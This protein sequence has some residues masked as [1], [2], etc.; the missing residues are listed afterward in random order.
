MRACVRL[1]CLLCLV[2]LTARAAN[3]G[4]SLVVVARGA[5]SGGPAPL[6]G[7]F[8]NDVMVGQ[9]TA[10]SAAPVAY[11]IPVRSLPAGA[12]I[13]IVYA[14]APDRPGVPAGTRSLTID[15]ITVNGA[16]VRPTDA[17]VVLDGQR[18]YP[19]EAKYYA[20]IWDGLYTQR[21][22]ATLSS[23][24][25][26]RFAAPVGVPDA[27]PAPLAPSPTLTVRARAASNA[28]GWPILVLRVN[29]T[30]VG[31]VQVSSTAAA[32][33]AVPVKSLPL[34]AKV[35]VVAGAWGGATGRGVNGAVIESVTMNGATVTSAAPDV[36]FYSGRNDVAL[37]YGRGPVNNF[38][39]LWGAEAYADHGTLRFTA[40][41][42]AVDAPAP[43]VAAQ[44]SLTVYARGEQV[45]GG[46]A[47]HVGVFVN[48]V[49]VGEFDAASDLTTPYTIPVRDVPAGA[50]IEMLFANATDRPGQPAGGRFLAIDR[51]DVNG[52]VVPATDA[53]VVIDEWSG[54]GNA[55]FPLAVFDGQ[56]LRTNL[57]NAYLGTTLTGTSVMRLTAPVG[58]TPLPPAPL[59]ARPALVV[60]ATAKSYNGVWP[61]VNVY[62]NGQAVGGFLANSATPKDYIIPTPVL[63]AGALIDV[64]S[65]STTPGTAG[66]SVAS[67][68]A[69]GVTI[70]ANS[71]DSLFVF[72]RNGDLPLDFGRGPGIQFWVRYG[73]AEFLEKGTLRLRAPVGAVPVRAPRPVPPTPWTEQLFNADGSLNTVAYESI[74]KSYNTRT[75]YRFGPRAGELPGAT[76][77][78]E[79][80]YQPD[81]N[82]LW[83]VGNDPALTS[84]FCVTSDKLPRNEGDE[85]NYLAQGNP[86]GSGAWQMSGQLLYLPDGKSNI[87]AYQQ[88]VANVRA[89][90]GAYFAFKV[91]G[92][93]GD[94]ISACM[95]M[96][97]SWF[98]DW[99]NR[100]DISNP[101]TPNALRLLS[102]VP[103]TPMPAVATARGN[104]QSS[105]A[106]FLA[107]ANGWIV[108]AGTGNDYSCSIF[109]KGCGTALKLPAGKV[110]TALAVTAMNEFVFAT[111]WDVVAHKGQLAVIAVSPESPA[112]IERG[113]NKRYGWGVQSWPAVH[114]LKLL[115]F[116]DLP[117]VAPSALSVT[118]STGFE[119]F[120]GHQNW[121]EDLSIQANRDA[122]LKRIGTSI[123]F[124]EGEPF[125]VLA[126]AGVALVASRAENKVA[127]VD[128]KPLL[129]YYRTMYLTTP[130]NF[131]ETA[132]GK[133]GNGAAQWP[134]TFSAVP[135]QKPTIAAVFNVPQPTAVRLRQ[136]SSG[137]NSL[138]Y[139]R[140]DGG[141]SYGAE[142]QR[143][144]FVASMD[145]T[146][147]RYDVSSL[148][149]LFRPQPLT[150][151]I[152]PNKVG[153]NPVQLAEPP[154]G[155][156][157]K[158]DILVVARGSREI[159]ALDYT[160]APIL[161]EQGK[162][163]VLRDTRLKDPVW[164]T[165]AIGQGGFG[166]SGKT[167]TL[168]A[169]VLT[170]LDYD[171]KTMHDYGMRLF[172]SSK[173]P[174]DATGA[175]AEEW[176]Y[177]GL[178]GKT[179][180]QF[181]YGVGVPLPGKPFMHTIDE[182]I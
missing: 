148:V 123:L 144:A 43:V 68:T 99:W 40:P 151:T 10:A 180:E 69:N 9:F 15:T 87:F 93:T 153:L 181:Q 101:L 32:D 25:A 76:P 41:V 33:Y 12:K 125:R 157:R 1:A 119:K 27:A 82:G 113:T 31:T 147:R 52:A 59:V 117:M 138:A 108:E 70:P 75:D 156:G 136:R 167:R 13:D 107:F 162:P 97:A 178:D 44:P 155:D 166:G 56:A 46:P 177:L 89:T 91:P 71:P 57:A 160:G 37:D 90:D 112:S 106:G 143:Y 116:V 129:S 18:D 51:I 55:V 95:R 42:G 120:R 152:L 81:P 134:P 85:A 146:L 53:G 83:N 131:A 64:A 163:F 150:E 36:I 2:A 34:G 67:V 158:D 47:P 102:R 94:H 110:P 127:F 61:V 54:D 28:G 72:Y 39:V 176:P 142:F 86:Y 135:G 38:W 14:N 179:V 103:G 22:Q 172:N 174:P 139:A 79:T 50:K 65:N 98:P 48:D 171:G 133:Q 92:E 17:G 168:G 3:T 126:D 74:G 130:E 141:P 30:V 170:V 66:L 63:P 88:G 145:G 169:R 114:G 23:T 6:A 60:R 124:G 173:T 84:R 19:G 159:R 115:G 96:F 161:D 149:S 122:W 8:V 35:D 175:R 80:V 26:L 62:V 100:N 132:Q 7:V 182:V 104:A 118:L 121:T 137:T 16:V 20:T 111:V 128:L 164:V 49:L 105:V 154:A 77:V 4:P 45:S 165:I 21:G 29:N 11:S 24:A 73:Q 140:G 58:A 5:F 109:S 78:T